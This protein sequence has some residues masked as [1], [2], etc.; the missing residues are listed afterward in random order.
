MVE[1]FREVRRVLRD[2]G[3]LWLNLGDS[4]APNWS[5]RRDTGGAGRKDNARDRWTRIDLAPGNLVG[6]P[7]RVA[8]ALQ[9]DG[10]WLRQDIIWCLSGGTLVYVRT[11]DGGIC[12]MTV[13]DMYRLKPNTA[14][15]W[16]GKEWTPVVGMSR[17]HRSGQDVELVLRSGERICCSPNHRFPVTRWPMV[18]PASEL[19]VGDILTQVQLPPPHEPKD[20][21]EIESDAAW[22]AGMCRG[23]CSLSR[24][25]RARRH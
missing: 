25:S 8:F 6:I 15:L 5:S 2:D 13:K 20:S 11:N 23:D 21:R 19:K 1:V 4:F 3:S 9:A 14:R 12:V 22:L 24:S 16:N 18:L 10:W 17:S 7:W